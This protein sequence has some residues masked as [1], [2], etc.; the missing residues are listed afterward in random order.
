MSDYSEAEY[1][2]TESPIFPIQQQ[3]R[4][5]TYGLAS[6]SNIMSL[7]YSQLIKHRKNLNPTAIGLDVA[8]TDNNKFDYSNNAD[9]YFY[10]EVIMR[11]IFIFYVIYKIFKIYKK[12]RG[13]K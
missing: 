9:E 12:K 6:D 8:I 10:R 2:P 4:Y 5:P 3:E 11:F 13:N 1:V 7:D